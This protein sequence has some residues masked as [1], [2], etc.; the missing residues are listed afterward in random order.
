MKEIVTCSQMKALD[1]HTI[2]E[3]GIPSCVLMERAALKCVEEAEKNILDHRR[4]CLLYADVEITGATGLRL[5][6]C[7]IL[8]ESVPIFFLQEKKNP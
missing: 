2:K 4:A 7:C 6:E 5:Q 8:R 3:M 1:N